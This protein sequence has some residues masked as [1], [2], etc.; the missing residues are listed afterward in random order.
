[1]NSRWAC[2]S[3]RLNHRR[4]VNDPILVHFRVRQGSTTR[5][6]LR[7]QLCRKRFALDLLE[8]TRLIRGMP[9]SDEDSLVKVHFELQEPE[10]GVGGESLWAAPVGT[11]LYELRNSPWHVRAVNWLDVVE[12]IP[13]SE[14][15]LPEFVRVHR[16]GGHR[17]M[18]VYMLND[19]QTTKD[20][21]LQ[22]CNELGCTWEGMDNRMYALDFPPEV[23][24]DPAIDYLESLQ[25]ANV[26]TWRLNE[27]E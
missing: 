25:D 11:N 18:H 5:Q 8:I 2:L 7:W 21:I 13:E 22:R 1:M 26:V 14:D 9:V 20:E 6:Q 17:T 24:I 4:S 12:A 15:Q 3:L 27:Y 23:D 10:M 16:R 19:K